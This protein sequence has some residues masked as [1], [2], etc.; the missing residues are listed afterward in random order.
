MSLKKFILK[1]AFLLIVLA[2]GA[3]LVGINIGFLMWFY[4]I[5]QLMLVFAGIGFGILLI[6]QPMECIEVMLRIYR[7]L[8]RNGE[9]NGGS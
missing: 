2:V 7:Y 3:Y 5:I 9:K 1:N 8:R 4:P 6:T